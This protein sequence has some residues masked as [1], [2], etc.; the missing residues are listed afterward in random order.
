M[1]K[2]LPPFLTV[3]RSHISGLGLL[4]SRYIK[5]GVTLGISHLEV[6]HRNGFI[7]I[8][9]TPLGGFG[10]H[11]D[12]PNCDKVEDDLHGSRCWKIISNTYILE[13]A[14]VTW[15]YTFYSIDEDEKKI[16]D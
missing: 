10:N 13:G 1:Y 2:P 14:E 3:G 16:R 8:H 7:T 6:K 11:S 4:A 5:K 12:S 9:R 15:K